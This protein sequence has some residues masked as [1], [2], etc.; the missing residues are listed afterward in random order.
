M[1]SQLAAHTDDKK[2]KKKKEKSEKKIV[3]EVA[4]QAEHE[5]PVRC[6]DEVNEEIECS[7]KIC[8]NV[9]E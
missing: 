9:N 6:L 2:K 7:E 1:R 8:T 5:E 3:E 4:K